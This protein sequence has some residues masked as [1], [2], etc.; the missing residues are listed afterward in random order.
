MSLTSKYSWGVDEYGR[1]HICRDDN[2]IILSMLDG[3]CGQVGVWILEEQD[4]ELER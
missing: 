3:Y 1:A 2:L 4:D